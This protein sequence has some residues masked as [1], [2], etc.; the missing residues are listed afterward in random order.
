MGRITVRDLAETAAR[1]LDIIVADR[2]GRAA[3]RLASELPRRVTAIEADA[4]SP[5]S[6][7][8][9]L[10][11]ATVVVN[12]CHHDFN[13]RVMD[14]ALKAG[15]HY[16]DLG[17]LFHV[18]RRQLARDAQF[19]RAGLLAVCGMGSAPGIV[20]VM[21]RAAASGLDRVREIQIAVGT[22]DATRRRGRSLLD[23]SYSIQTV[24]DE[25]SQPAALFTCGALWFVEPL[26]RPEA[27]RF[28]APVGLQHPACTL[29]S[30]LA[31]LPQSFRSKGV[32]EVS[33]KIAFPG[34]LADRLRFVHALGLTSRDPMTVNGRTIVPRD[35]LLALLAAAPRPV[36]AGPRDEYEVLRVTV[37]GKQGRRSVEVILDCHVPG[38]PSWG[39]GVDID[40]G[41][42]PSI[43]AQ[44]LAAG[45]L[46]ARGV[47]PPE[48]AIPPQ[49]FFRELRRR[50]MR[51]VKRRQHARGH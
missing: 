27:V 21:A 39:I 49:P 15:S 32:R 14:A 48:R 31:T 22:R 36:A 17:G 34:D 24:L 50:G 5:A 26:S 29:H 28:P 7:A 38:M 42:P 41:A 9:T 10:T 19:R 37:R 18:T 2:D 46:D 35:L 43:V 30:E 40:T 8:R 23:T 25:A 45:A 3:R 51:I 44:M 4:A 11:G 13:L 12:A 16:L 20:N 33:F 6:L 47:L 1:S